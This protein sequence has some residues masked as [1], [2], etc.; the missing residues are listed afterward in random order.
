MRAFNKNNHQKYRCLEKTRLPAQDMLTTIGLTN[1]RFVEGRKLYDHLMST[2]IFTLTMNKILHVTS[3]M[4]SF[5]TR[6]ID[7]Y[8]TNVLH[9]IFSY[10]LHVNN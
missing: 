6:A 8:R 2:I 9:V 4:M 3:K 1:N 5:A 7:G 10:K